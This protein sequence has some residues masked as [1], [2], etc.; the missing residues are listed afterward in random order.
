MPFPSFL[1]N[2]LAAVVLSAGA[3]PAAD[4]RLPSSVV[5][6]IETRAAQSGLSAVVLISERGEVAYSAAFGSAELRFGAAA[7]TDTRYRIASITKLFTSVLILQLAEAGAIRLDALFGDYLPDYPG[8]GGDRVTVR[9]LL[10]HTSGIAQF[11]TVSSFEE[12]VANGIPNYQRPMSSE[13][14]LRACCSGALSAAPGAAFNYN[15]AD[16]F[17]LGRI[18]ERLTGLSYAEALRTRILEPLGLRDTGI[19]RW[20][21]ITPRL[22]STYFAGE[23]TGELVADMPVYWENWYAA[24][25]MYSTADDLARFADAAFGARIISAS[26]LRELL[27]PA[28][29][30]YGLGLWSYGFE[31][32]GRTYRVAKRPGSIMGANAVLYR[33]LDEDITIVLLANTNRADLDMFAQKTAEALIDARRG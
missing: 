1:R 33:L 15:N 27:T 18:I 3:T 26:S 7:R 21:V 19:L 12:A 2:A 24:G 30:E 4:A 29:D 6:A 13:D 14:L 9:M 32:N 5:R 25:A 16:Y 10:N 11:D 31:R 8:A 20:D 23:Q 22:A 17:I 28:L